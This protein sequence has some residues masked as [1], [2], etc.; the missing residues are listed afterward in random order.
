METK[1]LKSNEASIKTDEMSEADIV[2]YIQTIVHIP[3]G[4][5][6]VYEIFG[7]SESNMV[8]CGEVVSSLSKDEIKKLLAE[9][10]SGQYIVGE[11]DDHLYILNMS[12]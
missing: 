12:A 6:E 4:L 9:K 8:D 11:K 1:L 5:D 3:P 2:D 7:V 10:T